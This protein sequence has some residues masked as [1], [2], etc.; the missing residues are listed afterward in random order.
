MA[1][2]GSGIIGGF[3]AAAG[4]GGR[5]R[6]FP[7][8]RHVAVQLVVFDQR[9]P[10]HFQTPPPR[11]G[12]EAC[13][14]S[15]PAGR[16]I[17]KREPLPGSLSTVISPP[18]I[19]QNLAD[20]QT[21]TGAVVPPGGGAVHLREGLEQL[22]QVL[23][24]DP[25]AGIADVHFGPLAIPNAHLVHRRCSGVSVRISATRVSNGRSEWRCPPLCAGAAAGRTGSTRATTSRRARLRIRA[26]GCS[27]S[28]SALT[29]SAGR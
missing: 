16:R 14:T 20:R 19:W 5:Q 24:A 27:R 26:D 9:Y 15:R 21:Q 25:D 29:K 7:A 2:S 6:P 4:A 1:P 18:I 28:C 17:E 22:A 3:G 10:A 12:Q 11:T 13:P 23:P 8:R